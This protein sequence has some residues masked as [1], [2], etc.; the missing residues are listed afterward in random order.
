MN[1]KIS[2]F[3]NFRLIFKSDE[4][5]SIVYVSYVLFVLLCAILFIFYNEKPSWEEW[6][7]WMKKNAEVA[8]NIE[9]QDLKR[10]P[11]EVNRQRCSRMSR[12]P[13]VRILMTV[14][15]GLWPAGNI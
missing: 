9:R 14:V 11:E 12:F 6:H 2:D 1:K 7:E 10:M 13:V 15:L 8:T 3:Y 5:I 4:W